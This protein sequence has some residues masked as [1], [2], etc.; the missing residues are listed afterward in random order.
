MGKGI[1]L[2]GV[3]TFCCVLHMINTNK[4]DFIL[5]ADSTGE[6]PESTDRLIARGFQQA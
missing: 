6:G 5:T 1:F 4:Y 3:E 2:K